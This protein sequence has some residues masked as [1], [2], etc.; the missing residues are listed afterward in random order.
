MEIANGKL[1]MLITGDGKKIFIAKRNDGKFN[2][3]YPVSELPKKYHIF[4]NYAKK[5]CETL[6]QAPAAKISNEIGKFC[7]IKCLNELNFEAYLV[8]GYKVFYQ[9]GA[10]TLILVNLNGEEM[11]INIKEKLS[12]LNKELQKAIRISFNYMDECVRLYEKSK[13]DLLSEEK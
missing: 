8:T 5:V 9:I 10:S 2:K 12:S 1:L 11:N 7:L 6:K 4:Y 3:N 13:K